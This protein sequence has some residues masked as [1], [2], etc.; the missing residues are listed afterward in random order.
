MDGRQFHVRSWALTGL[1]VLLLLALG[2]GLYRTQIV[3]GAY[4][5]ELSRRKIANMET[6][7]KHCEDLF[8]DYDVHVDELGNR[9]AYGFGLG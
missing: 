3:N 4:Y 6:I 5:A 1:L 7:E 2:V 8:D 9:Y